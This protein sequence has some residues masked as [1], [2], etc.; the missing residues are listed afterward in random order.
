MS[1]ED[2]LSRIEEL[3]GFD[4]D[5]LEDALVDLDDDEIAAALGERGAFDL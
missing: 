2:M 5:F 1:P 4:P 3:E